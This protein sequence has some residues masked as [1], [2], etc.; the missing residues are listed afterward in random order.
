LS[1]Y[2]SVFETLIFEP[3][4]TG[5]DVNDKMKGR[6]ERRRKMSFIVGDGY[7]SQFLEPQQSFSKISKTEA[8][9]NKKS[10]VRLGS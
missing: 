2:N 4:G 3:L 8:F 6:L 5:G 10:E 1:A 9:T 7:F